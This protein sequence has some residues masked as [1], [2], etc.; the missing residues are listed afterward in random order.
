MPR[1]GN[2]QSVEVTAPVGGVVA[3]NFYLIGG[4]FG[5]A[6][7]TV[8]E[9]SRVNLD[10]DANGRYYQDSPVAY[11]VGDVVYFDTVTNLFVNA[12]GVNDCVEVGICDNASAGANNTFSFT[13]YAHLVIAG[14]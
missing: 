12:V 10:I 3:G 5:M 6:Y 11:A 8:D 4:F 13:R 9:G 1:I 14:A 2:G 7:A